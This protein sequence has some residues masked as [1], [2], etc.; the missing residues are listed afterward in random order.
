MDR[1]LAIFLRGA[2]LRFHLSFF[3]NDEGRKT[4]WKSRRI[5]EKAGMLDDRV[6]KQKRTPQAEIMNENQG[7]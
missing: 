2:D 4:T 5:G 6:K 7:G 1:K 3:I